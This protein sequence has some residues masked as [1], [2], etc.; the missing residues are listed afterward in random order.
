MTFSAPPVPIV[1]DASLAVEQIIEASPRGAAPWIAWIAAQRIRLVPAHFW[2]EVAN[3]LLVG[4]R[5]DPGLVRQ[6][7]GMLRAVGIESVDAHERRLLEAIGLA[8]QHGLSVY[9]ALY[10]QLAI[11]TDATLGTLDKAMRR[12]A[13]AEG[14]EVESLD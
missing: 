2:P 3:G 5:L 12:A 11:E 7:I 4:N 13:E 10:V 8:S 6:E 9:D 1:I 14:V